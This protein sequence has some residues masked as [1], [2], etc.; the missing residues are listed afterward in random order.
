MSDQ[1]LELRC[2]ELELELCV[3]ASRIEALERTL[4]N[5]AA[6]RD[7]NVDAICNTAEQALRHT[8]LAP[9]QDK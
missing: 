7:A 9:E 4:R 5:I 8:F 2:N 3:T 6:A 1:H